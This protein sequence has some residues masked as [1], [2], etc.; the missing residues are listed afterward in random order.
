MY[1]KDWKA[2]CEQANKGSGRFHIPDIN[3]YMPEFLSKSPRFFGASLLHAAAHGGHIHVVRFLLDNNASISAVNSAHQTAIKLAAENG[4]VK[5]VKALYDAGAVADQTDL[6]HAAANNRLEV[7][8]F[9]LKAGVKDT[10]LR[11]D[12]SFYW[13]ETKSRLQSTE[14][15]FCPVETARCAVDWERQWEEL[16]DDGI[17]ELF[18]DKHLILCQTALHAAIASGH[19]NVVS[20][21]IS[22]ETS[23]LNCYDYTGRT[24]LHEAVRRNDEKLVEIL[25]EKQPQ[26]IHQNCN[27]WQ[28]VGKNFRSGMLKLAFRNPLLITK[29]FVI[30]DTLLYIL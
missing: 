1:K 28:Q 10:C 27:H 13:L 24:P 9:L 6:C 5:V 18:D 21:L 20:I 30:V 14:F 22:E 11:C 2:A 26:T 19:K 15:D 7:V 4:H 25:L 23:A 12:G 17:G 16:E 8:K 29:L 3:V